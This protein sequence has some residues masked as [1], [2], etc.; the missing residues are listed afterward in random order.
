MKQIPTSTAQA[1][2]SETDKGVTSQLRKD[3]EAYTDFFGEDSMATNGRA[4]ITDELADKN[5]PISFSRYSDVS[6][7][8]ANW[9]IQKFIVPLHVEVETPFDPLDPTQVDLSGLVNAPKK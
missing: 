5:A 3:L 6:D 2:A 8:L 9:Y 4:E 7:L 1:C